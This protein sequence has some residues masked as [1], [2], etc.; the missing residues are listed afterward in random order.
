M[1]FQKTLREGLSKERKAQ[2]ASKQEREAYSADLKIEK[3][4]RQEIGS[5]MKSLQS[6]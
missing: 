3:N 5:A 6:V 1:N 4:L 2:G